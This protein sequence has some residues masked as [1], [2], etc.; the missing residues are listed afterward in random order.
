M[1]GDSPKDRDDRR[2]TFPVRYSGPARITTIDI[3]ERAITWQRPG[4]E[5]VIRLPNIHQ[6]FVPALHDASSD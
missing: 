6:A 5:I 3:A 4:D 1:S 2:T